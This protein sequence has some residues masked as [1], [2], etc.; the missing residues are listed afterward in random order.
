MPTSYHPNID[1]VSGTSL[2]IA[3]TLY[4]ATGKALDVTNCQLSWCLLDPNAN[5][6]PTPTVAITKTDAVH[7]G[8]SIALAKTDTAL[9]PGRYTDALQVVAGAQKDIFWTGQIR[10]AANPFA[11]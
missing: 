10:V 2:T 7:G 1:V 5:P 11:V 6:V 9:D 4:D 8:I 3:G